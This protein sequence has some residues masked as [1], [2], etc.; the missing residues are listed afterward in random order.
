ML[1]CGQDQP[2]S[3][4]RVV[5]RTR[6]WLL[7]LTVLGPL[8]SAGPAWACNVP[9]FR[10]ALERWPPDPYEFILFHQGPLAPDLEKLVAELRTVGERDKGRANVEL[11]LVDLAGIVPE[12][13]RKLW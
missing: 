12:P 6:T 7:T 10:Y 3:N 11:K 8:L 1:T 9:V 4:P 5:M 13:M 2:A